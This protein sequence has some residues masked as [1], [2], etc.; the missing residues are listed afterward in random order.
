MGSHD[1]FFLAC[2]HILLIIQKSK[3]RHY[4][5]ATVYSMLLYLIAFPRTLITC[6][7]HLGDRPCPRCL[8]RKCDIPALGTKNDQRNRQNPTSVR[9]D[10]NARKYDVE[11]A[12]KWIYENGMIIDS[13]AIKRLLGVKSQTPTRVSYFCVANLIR[14]GNELTGCLECIFNPTQSVWFRISLHGCTRSPS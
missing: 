11:R 2:S 1:D 14:V 9:V 10:N 3:L 5:V 7:K 13:T 4:S 6:I 8:I 12:R